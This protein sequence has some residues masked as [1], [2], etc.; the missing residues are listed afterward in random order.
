MTGLEMKYFVLNPKS[1]V[2]GDPYAAASRKGMRFYSNMIRKE[3]PELAD[4]LDVW[5]DKETKAEFSLYEE[6]K[7]PKL[8]LMMD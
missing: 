5:V 6:D 8:K 3:N 1:K 7:S 4:G 2:A